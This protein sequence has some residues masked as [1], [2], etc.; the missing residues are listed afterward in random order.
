MSIIL[1]ITYV[2]LIAANIYYK[3][4]NNLIKDFFYLYDFKISI[5]KNFSLTKIVKIPALSYFANNF[6]KYFFE[7]IKYSSY[8][9]AT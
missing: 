9:K 2:W 3:L 5:I 4:F 1:E 7:F 8:L 6:C